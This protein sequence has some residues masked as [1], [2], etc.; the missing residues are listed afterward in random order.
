M[1]GM[2][3]ENNLDR[4]VGGVGQGGVGRAEI[5]TDAEAGAPLWSRNATAAVNSLS[6]SSFLTLTIAACVEDVK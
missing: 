5:D 4:G 3:V 6:F 2:V 1:G